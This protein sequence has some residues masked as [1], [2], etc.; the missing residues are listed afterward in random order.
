VTAKAGKTIAEIAMIDKTITVTA[1]AGK[2][3]AEIAMIDK[4]ITVT[5]MIGKTA[6][7]GDLKNAV[8]TVMGWY[9]AGKMPLNI[10]GSI[11]SAIPA[12]ALAPA[13]T[14]KRSVAG[15]PERIADSPMTTA[16]VTAVATKTNRLQVS[17]EKARWAIGGLSCSVPFKDEPQWREWLVRRLDSLSANT[18]KLSDSAPIEAVS[19][20]R[21][22]S[23]RRAGYDD[24]TCGGGGGKC[25]SGFY[26][27]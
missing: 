20:G 12:S 15:M 18:C 22:R 10:A 13:T 1:T 23:K 24:S 8:D 2:T 25:R 21:V 16:I 26:Q 27:Q 7:G 11:R 5:A 6:V 9:G 4:T 14:A 19:A 3:I 17:F